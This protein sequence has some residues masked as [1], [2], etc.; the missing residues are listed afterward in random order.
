MRSTVL[1]QT[2]NSFSNIT[3]VLTSLTAGQRLPGETRAEQTGSF[4]PP[5]SV[6]KRQYVRRG[7]YLGLFIPSSLPPHT[8]T[9]SLGPRPTKGRRLSTDLG[10]RHCANPFASCSGC[11]GLSCP[12]FYDSFP[13]RWALS[14]WFLKRS[15]SSEHN[16]SS[17]QPRIMVLS[18]AHAASCPATLCRR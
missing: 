17:S 6:F 11:Q 16:W 3:A 5:F 13:T 14:A 4:S 7:E 9:I 18:L 10:Q 12:T 1:R 2:Q 15:R 8:S